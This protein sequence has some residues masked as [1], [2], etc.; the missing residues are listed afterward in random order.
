MPAG[1][2]LKEAL[3]SSKSPE[4]R[5]QSLEPE[6]DGKYRS[7]L[8][9]RDNGAGWRPA[10]RVPEEPGVERDGVG[11]DAVLDRRAVPQPSCA[12]HRGHAGYGLCRSYHGIVPIRYN[13]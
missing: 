5:V 9:I 1:K 11:V 4:S 13:A 3:G 2:T 10:D 6:N 7:L 8:H 12:F